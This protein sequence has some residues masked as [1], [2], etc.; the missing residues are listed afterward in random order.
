MNVIVRLRT[1]YLSQRTCQC[2]DMCGKVPACVS[3]SMRIVVYS[4]NLS[5]FSAICRLNKG[6]K[7]DA[8]LSAPILMSEF[9]ALLHIFFNDFFCVRRS[10]HGLCNLAGQFFGQL[11]I[12]LQKILD[13]FPALS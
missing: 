9:L 4:A 7:C 6:Q 5:H 8:T 12:V 3:W 2:S 1:L 13:A 11:G 10:V